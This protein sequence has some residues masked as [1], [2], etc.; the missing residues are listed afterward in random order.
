MD[1]NRQSELLLAMLARDMRHNG[2]LP[3]NSPGLEKK[4]AEM[5]QSPEFRGLENPP[6]LNELRIL[7]A[8]ASA[9]EGETRQSIEKE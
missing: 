3:I 4:L 7:Y 1:A 2:K 6:T 9:K 8:K 5:V